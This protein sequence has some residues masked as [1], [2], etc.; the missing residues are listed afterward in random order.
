MKNNLLNEE[1]KRMQALAGIK[2]INEN[3]YNEKR[4]DSNRN[5][6]KELV[7][8]RQLTDSENPI[9]TLKKFEEDGINYIKNLGVEDA[10]ILWRNSYKPK[11]IKNILDFYKV[12]YE[13]NPL[14]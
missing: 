4:I 9:E 10:T 2:N 11:E 3:S 6:I 8:Y 7:F 1:K 5:G 12:N 14:W 13:T